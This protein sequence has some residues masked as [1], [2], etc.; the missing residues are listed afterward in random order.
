M[1]TKI[2]V[3]FRGRREV[4]AVQRALAVYADYLQEVGDSLPDLPL[5]YRYGSTVD[6]GYIEASNRVREM[7]NEVASVLAANLDAEW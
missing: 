5:W 6:K 7:A 3:Q 1:D 4:D 2:E